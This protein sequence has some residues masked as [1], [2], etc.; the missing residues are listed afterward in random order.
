MI[1]D[2]FN[3][4]NVTDTCAVWNLVG[5]DTLFRCARRVNV[6]FLITPTVFY[7]CFVKTRGR[8]PSAGRTALQA[9]LSRHLGEKEVTR[10]GVSIEDLQE[11]VAMA[12]R[13]GLHK[14]LGQGE[15]S[16]AA[17]ARQLGHAAVLTDNRRDFRAI[18]ILVDDRLQ[19]T[20][21]LLGWLYVEGLLN[22]SDVDDVV[23]EHAATEGQMAN[24]YKQAH[25]LACEKVLVRRTA[26]APQERGT[27][28]P[29]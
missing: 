1:P 24:V 11:T 17:L 6:A 23:A 8:P 26:G 7:E 3:R 27:E 22:D 4:V 20:P 14:R 21:Q 10:L 2:D 28:E 13:K 16:C 19:K 29:V 12:K 15:L 9:K 5:A 25:L 18:R